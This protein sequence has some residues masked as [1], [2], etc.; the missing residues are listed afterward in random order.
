MAALDHGWP[1]VH[2]V[3]DIVVK[4]GFVLDTRTIEDYELVYFPV[5]TDT[6]Y[7]LLGKP[8]VLDVPCFV[9]TRPD[10]RHLY[11][12]GG[13][14]SVRHLFVHFDYEALRH[15]DVR[16]ISLL[17]GSAV[18][19][20]RHN[21]L[22][23]GLIRQMLSIAG[24]QPLHW[25]SRLSALLAAALEELGASADLP[26]EDAA[27]QMPIQITNAMAYMEEHLAE[28]LTIERIARQTGWSHEHFTRIFRASVGM[29]PKRALV[30][31]RL[32]RAEQLMM[33]GQSSVKQIAYE[34]G[35]GDEHHFS[36]TYKKLRGINAS[37]Y[38]ERCRNPI[39]RHIAAALDTESPYGA[40]RHIVVNNHIK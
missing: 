9:F 34:V 7:E 2:S 37:D 29:T 3:G 15:A 5:G 24:K 35:F 25:K 39:F 20:V 40:S 31:Q 17:H 21:S 23:P 8:Y 26:P 1:I 18:H 19:P 13:E 33:N 30:E 38:I 27:L 10:E 12:F 16:L 28:D 14:K 32:R 22:I 36:K 6:V 4:A 11:R